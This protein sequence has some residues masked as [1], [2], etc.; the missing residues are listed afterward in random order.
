MKSIGQFGWAAGAVLLLGVPGHA[1]AQAGPSGAAAAA[2]TDVSR[3]TLEEVVVIG[4]TKRSTD[5]QHVPIAV[6]ALTAATLENAAL[7]NVAEIDS[8]VPNIEIDSTSPFS[9]SSSVLSASIRGI[10]QNDFAFNLEPGVGVYVDGVYYARTIGAVVDLLD[11]EQ[12]EVL[13][14]PQGTLFG[15]NTIGGA[16]NIVTRKPGADFGWSSEVTTGRYDRLDVKGVV[17]VPLRAESLL[18]QFAFSSK[19]RD[20]YQDRVGFQAAPVVTDGPAFRR[21]RFST[22]DESGGEKQDNFRGK[23]SW[24]VNDSTELLFAA[25]YLSVDEQG[26]PATLVNTIINPTDPVPSLATSYNF[27]I[28]A[29]AAALMGAFL[30]QACGVRALAG[31]ALASVNTDGDATN[32]RLFYGSQFISGKDTSFAT[33]SNFSKLDTSGGS[34]TL[35]LEPSSGV[36]L[37]SITAFRRLH[38]KFGTDLDGSPL[39][40]AD[41]S[42]DTLQNQYSEEVQL[43]GV[44]LGG[45][46]EWLLGGYYFHERGNLTDFVPFAEGLV[47]IFGQNSFKN[48]AFAGFASATYHVDD[49]LSVSV[50]LRHSDEDKEFEGKQRDLNAFV[51]KLPIGAVFPDPN[52]PTRIYPLG[53]QHKSFKDLD[54]RI[55]LQY[56][57]TE[58]LFS[59][60][61]YTQGTKTGGWSTRLQAPVTPDPNVAPDFDSEK[62]DSYEIGLKSNALDDR[63]RANVAAFYTVYDNI[64]VTVQRDTSPVF[65]NA[66]DGVV[67]GIE[68]ELEALPVERLALRG[69]AG[70][71]DAHYTKLDPLSVL[72]KGNQ[73]VNTP[74]FSLNVS[75]DYEIPLTGVL[76]RLDGGLGLHLDWSHKNHVD[77]D[78]ENNPYFYEGR[79]NVLN[80][81]LSFAPKDAIWEIVWGVHNVTDTR[82]VVSGF[83]NAGVGFTSA[84]YS[85]PREWY[86]TLRMT[87]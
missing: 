71:L 26:T 77:N 57:I 7:G 33:G 61:S 37:K 14:G 74:D 46:L 78:A 13:K 44:A 50:G 19:R 35:T 10:G 28:S 41:L 30:Q 21:A 62:A 6:S 75:G 68:L 55:S 60:A 70:V 51:S 56:R 9:G 31:T 53:E 22:P 45:S 49:A 5:V 84:I 34:A 64:Q 69:S 15:R 87:Y 38:A 86:L 18:S 16:L 67:R 12:V 27:C 20:G 32:D 29:D 40:I 23:L 25:D 1:G 85:R 43:S 63:L 36:T 17:D 58:E 72:Q 39:N 54:S 59:Y 48:E 11:V 80:A 42:F 47:Q 82:F 73:F 24:I 81:A 76:P 52:D 4:T 2:T 65:E 66:G 3:V 79:I 8:I 83:Q